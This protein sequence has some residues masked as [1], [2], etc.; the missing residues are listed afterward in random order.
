MNEIL[1]RLTVLL[2]LFAFAVV[3]AVGFSTGVKPMV[4]LFRATVAFVFF[5]VLG[6]VGFKIVLNGILEELA[7]HKRELEKKTEKKPEHAMAPGP[8]SETTEKSTTEAE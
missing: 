4:S 7:K 6:H 5:G 1:N 8:S 2:A 3:A